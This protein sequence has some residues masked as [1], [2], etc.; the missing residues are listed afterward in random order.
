[1]KKIEDKREEYISVLYNLVA[2]DSNKGINEFTSAI[3]SILI[4]IYNTAY[5]KI[6]NCNDINLMK[7]I[8]MHYRKRIIIVL[9]EYVEMYCEGKNFEYE[10]L[11]YNTYLINDKIIISVNDG[12]TYIYN[13]LNSLYK[14]KQMVKRLKSDLRDIFLP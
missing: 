1:M 9:N 6:N 14:R 11:K 4:D 2:F 5:N 7:E 13:K 10:K 12:F 3:N 8:F